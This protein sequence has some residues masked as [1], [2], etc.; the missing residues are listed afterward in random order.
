M[1]VSQMLVYA[2]TGVS[3]YEPEELAR[4]TA[5]DMLAERDV[6]RIA[7]EYAAELEATFNERQL[8]GGNDA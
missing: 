8:Q 4:I 6:R 2:A 7:D 3:G 1:T 5:A